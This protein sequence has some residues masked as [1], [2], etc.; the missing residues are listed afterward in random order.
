MPKRPLPLMMQYGT[1]FLRHKAGNQQTV[2]MGS[3]SC[4]ITT[5]LATFCSMSVVTWFRPYLMTCGF[6]VF[7]SF[8]SF[9]CWAVSIS[10]AFLASLVSG[11]YFFN[12]RRSVAAWFLSIVMLNWLIAGGIFRR[13]IMIFFM[14]CRRTYLGHR[15][16]R[17]RSRFGWMSPPKRKFLGVFS[18]SGFLTAFAFFAAKGALGSFLPVFAALPMVTENKKRDGWLFKGVGSS[19]RIP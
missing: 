7:S 3:T 18:K 9:F 12:R 19:L 2:S 11:W 15:T 4:A 6:L 13:M 10:L 17:V 8:P 16:K 1:S 5:S 14:R